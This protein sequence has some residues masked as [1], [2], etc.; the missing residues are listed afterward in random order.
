MIIQP[1]NMRFDDKKIFMILS[2]LP[3]VGKTTLA[4]S[5]PNPLLIDCDQ[6]IVRVDPAHRKPTAD[7]KT[8]EECATTPL[9]QRRHV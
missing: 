8:Y 1:E 3:G 7:A 4:L 2:G 9:H 6:G 5:A